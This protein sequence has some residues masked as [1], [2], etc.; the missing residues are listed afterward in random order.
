MVRVLC[1]TGI[2]A[3]QRIAAHGLAAMSYLLTLPIAACIFWASTGNRAAK[4][5]SLFV[6]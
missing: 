3:A 1:R 6:L 5:D 2:F 4:F